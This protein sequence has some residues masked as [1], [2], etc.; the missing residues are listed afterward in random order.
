M[1]SE[2]DFAELYGFVLEKLP[3]AP[4]AK[5]ARMCRAFAAIIGRE[6]W[7]RSLNAQA[8]LLEHAEKQHR[9]LALDFDNQH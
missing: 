6:K 9:E 5:R 4:V 1:Q 2:R 8:A 7:A 3:D